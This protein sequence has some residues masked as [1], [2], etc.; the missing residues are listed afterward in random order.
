MMHVP[1]AL[2]VQRNMHAD[3][4]LTMQILLMLLS[5]DQRGPDM[6]HHST[7]RFAGASG[8][9]LTL[10]YRSSSLVT[11]HDNQAPDQARQTIY[12]HDAQLVRESSF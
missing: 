4:L 2:R 5:S 12:Y 8:M 7:I 11:E 6:I 10:A 3:F 9:H 1:A